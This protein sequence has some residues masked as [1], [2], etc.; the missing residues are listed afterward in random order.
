[1]LEFANAALKFQVAIASF[2]AQRV[3]SMLPGSNTEPMRAFQE[4]LYK[5]GEAAKK[6]FTTNTA[7]FG[8]FQFGDKAQ[9]AIAG[10]VN[11]TLSLKVLNPNYI[12]QMATGLVQGSTDAA[13]AV[14]TGHARHILKEQFGNT[15][16]VIGFVNHV[17]APSKLSS[18]GTYPLE[19][20][21]DKC[22]SH[23]DYPALWYIE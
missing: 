7:L 11:D 17:D 10:M 20:M 2:G 15:F 22:Y 4:N 8:A 12:R 21:I 14:A 9:S 6:D 13:G 19:E 3:I 18:D 16:D 5:A 23:G 1:M